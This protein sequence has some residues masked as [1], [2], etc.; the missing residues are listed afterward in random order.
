MVFI[1]NSITLISNIEI[2]AQVHTALKIY[3]KK[4]NTTFLIYAILYRSPNN[5]VVP[6]ID[7]QEN[8]ILFKAKSSESDN[9]TIIGDINIDLLKDTTVQNKY[10]TFM[11]EYGNL[12]MINNMTR[13]A[14]NTCLDHIFM[15][16][17]STKFSKSI[18]SPITITDHYP[19]ANI[20]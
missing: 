6:F 10:L 12:K 18:I 13:Y 16:C 19:M 4:W 20:P 8:L 17:K 14:S 7:E 9:K 1:H 3:L 2:L 5:N 11:A 15:K